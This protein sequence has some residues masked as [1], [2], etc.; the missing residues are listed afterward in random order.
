MGE[1]NE[2]NVDLDRLYWWA[3]ILDEARSQPTCYP[4]CATPTYAATSSLLPSAADLIDSETD[5]LA[6]AHRYDEWLVAELA[7]ISDGVRT[8]ANGYQQTEQQV[9]SILR[10]SIDSA[11]P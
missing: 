3:D 4:P 8:S 6:R 9:T 5:A 1:Y 10:S 7:E 2:V 11:E